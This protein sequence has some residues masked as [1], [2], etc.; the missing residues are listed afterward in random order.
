MNI[1]GRGFKIW[2]I[3]IGIH[4][5][6]IVNIFSKEKGKNTITHLTYNFICMLL[7]EEN[8]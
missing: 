7:A 5:Y 8:M 4:H 1:F 3:C 6:T 2:V